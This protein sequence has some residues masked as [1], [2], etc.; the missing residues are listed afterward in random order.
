LT[1]GTS[2][3]ALPSETS[4]GKR[5]KPRP[6]RGPFKPGEAFG[7]YHI[8]RLLGIGGMG[9][10]YQAWDEELGVAVAIK[11]IRPEV[12]ADPEAAAQ[13]ERRFKRELL[14]ARQVTHKN[15]I[16]IHDL[17]EMAGMK[18]ITMSYVNGIDLSTLLKQEGKLEV[19]RVMRI[20][21]P[22]VSGLAA[23]HAAGVVHRD[24]KPA[25]VMIGSSGDAFIMDFGIARSI[26]AGVQADPTAAGLPA[27][28]HATV[29]DAGT[30]MA[31]SILGTMQYMAP[32]Q[33]QG[34]EVDHRA[35]IYA[36]GLI[37]YDMLVGR[38]RSEQAESAIDEL[39]GRMLH[40]PVSVRALLPEVPEGLDSLISKCLEPDPAKR[41]RTTDELAAALGRL[42][43]VGEVIPTRRVVGM[44]LLVAVGLLGL[45]LTAGT[46]WYTRNLLPPPEHDPVTVMIADL[47]NTTNDAEFDGSLEPI[48]KLAL[49]GAGFISAYSR[50][51]LARVQ[52]GPVPERLDE[53]AAQEVATK[54]G[55]GVVLSGSVSRRGNAYDLALRATQAVTGE[56]IATVDDTASR[57][58]QVLT[59]AADLANEIREALGDET[60]S[61]DA[62][63]FARDT[64][65]AVSLEAVR[66]YAQAVG[67]LSNSQFKEARQGFAKAVE[68]D[69]NFGLAYAGMAIASWNLR[70]QQEAE[71]L[72]AEA[73]RHVDSMTERERLRTRGLVYLISSDYEPCV[74]EFSD[75]V[76]RY[77]A[78]VSALNNLATCST[79]LR[80]MRRAFEGMQKVVEILPNRVMYKV[81]LALYAAYGSDFQTA[82]EEAKKAAELNPLG[83]LPEAFAQH[84]LGQ[85]T[86]A[87]ESYRRLEES[88]PSFAWSGLGDLAL[89]EG[90]FQDAVRILTD[91]ANAE[92]AANNTSQAA[93]KDIAVA[94]VHLA[95]RQRPAALAA[96]ERA[97]KLST[98][99]RIR[100]LAARVFIELGESKR[101]LDIA[102]GLAKELPAEPRAFAKV[103][104]GQAALRSENVPKALDALSSANEILDTWFGRL[105][106][107]RA[108]LQGERY[109]QA[110]SEFDRC[111]TRR[112]ELFLDEE[113]RFGLLPQVYYYRGLARQGL[114]SA[115]FAESYRMY[116]DIRGKANED[117]LL[118]EVRKRISM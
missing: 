95:A 12:M 63:R 75:L 79:G 113:P 45:V 93:A 71:R 88:N 53:A 116:L 33:A 110:D 48:L 27:N 25:N 91:A 78:D 3:T 51:D 20:I 81:N 47:T 1:N 107:G 39:K 97:L 37:V 106:L 117:P 74:K 61:D 30:T 60:T 44:P 77:A 59:V 66:D 109:T 86:Q 111:I 84:G 105:E 40:A 17:G 65:S 87:E 82:A 99:V 118:E 49:E 72:I 28:L 52:P 62:K 34:L 24:L 29:V 69:P 15:V 13:I 83:L 90:R 68:R 104:E 26:S 67:A 22:V 9:A 5:R 8:I 46:W 58:D 115:G 96:A 114:K 16:R 2:T 92:L 32:E 101:G 76:A 50:T 103:L 64:L 11:V 21:R 98:A 100:F 112:G 56:V 57:K 19:P 4:T 7:R 70:E 43:D 108:Y 35:D 89:Y 80:D 41:F 94:H 18:Y 31:G 36:F 23:A 6:D 38:R 55:L 85:L 42:D 54:Q 10:V 102:A 73:V 14:L